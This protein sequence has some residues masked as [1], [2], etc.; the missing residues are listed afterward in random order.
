MGFARSRGAV[1]R[2]L[3]I[4]AMAAVLLPTSSA[5]AQEEPPSTVAPEVGQASE[6]P[7]DKTAAGAG[8]ASN[9][10]Q[11]LVDTTARGEPPP[12]GMELSNGLVT[13]EILSA[14]PEA[15]ISASVT[16]LGGTVTGSV[17]G[18]LVQ[19]DVPA[20][21][22]A[23]LEAVDG[24]GFV[25]PPVQGNEPLEEAGG[26]G[27]GAVAQP[28]ASWP[29]NLTVGE[30]VVKT[31]ADD[32][33]Q[34]GI[35]G[36]GIT[37]GI[38]DFFG[39]AQW[40]QAAASGDLPARPASFCRDNGS[41]CTV[42]GSS[43][44][45]VAVAEMIHESA[46]GA[47]L[48]VA[49]AITASDKQ[50]AVN[51][52]AANGVDIV[53]QSL[54][55]EYDGP[56]NG[57][58]ALA[59]VVN[60]A[61]AQGMLWDQSAGNSGGPTH[62]GSYWRSTFQDVDADKWVEFASGDE[63]LGF[64][65]GFLNGLRWDDWGGSRTD[66]DMYIY[67]DS[68]ATVLEASGL[69]AQGSGAP[70]IEHPSTGTCDSASDVD[71][72][73]VWVYSAGGGTAGDILEF[74]TNTAAVEH[75]SNPYA[76]SGPF[77]DSAN[78]G[79]LS[80]GAVDP[81]NGTAIASYS[82]NGPT[83]DFR[84]K[85]DV[86]A[87]ACV[88]SVTYSPS[89]FNGTSSATPA[90][91]GAAALVRQIAPAASP[92]AVANFFRQTARVDRGPVGADNVYGHG[93]VRLPAPPVLSH[94]F[95]DV[96]AWVDP[97]VDFAWIN[98]FLTGYPNN[99][100]RPNNNMTRASVVRM[101][102]RFSGSPNPSQFPGHGF[103]D[104]PAWVDDAVR[105]AAYDPPG[106]AQPVITGYG[107][108][109]RPDSSITRAQVTRMLHRLAGSPTGY[110][111]HGMSDVPA[112]VDAAVRW[113]VWDPP[114]ATPPV[115]TGYPNNTYRPDRPVTRAELTRMFDRYAHTAKGVT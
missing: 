57:T 44:H 84:I 34:A 19:A 86:S 72:L 114:G 75:S 4:V 18:H 99:T 56:G 38:I 115:A 104:V 65:C 78:A 3:V 91:T 40:D 47:K 24:V 76:A 7:P 33:L 49:S 27:P 23:D 92:A 8:L 58:G 103:V 69:A 112:W 66:Y 95:S 60:S 10:L 20:E 108:Q 13:V 102:Y 105:W 110:P 62:S 85:P 2:G 55:A 37:V 81:P 1:A 107:N 73:R 89:C 97:S 109:F 41:V 36:G 59:A 111:F 39:G 68:A 54:T 93:E 29:P 64:Y 98:Q 82:S 30:Q 26:D 52:F 71:Y 6:P 46:P 100:F 50:A 31:N 42:W 83:N 51:W 87:A 79:M 28:L 77:S 43:N 9:E 94:P 16:A 32:W 101:L 96:P 67:D 48:L 88:Q 15:E 45:G 80:I 53:S 63:T 90:T 106:S 25:R 113:A 35:W 61:V 5:G 22:L 12:P 74:L 21:R 14:R 11:E 70:P 17:P